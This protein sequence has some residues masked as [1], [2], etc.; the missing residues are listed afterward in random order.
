MA[1]SFAVP[2]ARAMTPSPD[3][4]RTIVLVDDDRNILTSVSVL[5]EA[6]GF[7]VRAFSDGVESPQSWVVRKL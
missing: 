1:L 6:E 5:L 2:A 4:Q 7:K 3:T